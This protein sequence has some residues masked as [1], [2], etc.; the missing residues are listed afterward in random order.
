MKKLVLLSGLLLLLVTA[1]QSTDIG[2]KITEPIRNT[3]INIFDTVIKVQ[4]LDALEVTVDSGNL[5][6]NGGFESGLDSWGACDSD[7][8]SVTN[9]PYEGNNALSLEAGN[10]FYQSV[11]ASV[12]QEF[13]LQLEQD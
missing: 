10:C 1:C 5:F 4:A 8:I 6:S 3:P 12:D 2:S 7:N 11:E 13:N 9:K